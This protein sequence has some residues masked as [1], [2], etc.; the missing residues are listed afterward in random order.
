MIPIVRLSGAVFIIRSAIKATA[1]GLAVFWSIVDIWPLL[2]L[3]LLLAY[4]SG[5]VM[6]LV[7][8]WANKKHF[9]RTFIKGSFEGWWFTRCV[10]KC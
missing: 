9:P 2:G 1:F 4:A 5:V 6:W 7:D 8:T 10:R 3:S